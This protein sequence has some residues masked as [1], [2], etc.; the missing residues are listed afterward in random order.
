VRTGSEANLLLSG[1]PP[2]PSAY[3]EITTLD[4]ATLEQLMSALE[5]RAAN[6][7]ERAMRES[8]LSFMGLP[9]GARVLE[10]GCGTGAVSRDVAYRARIGE[11]VGLDPSPVFIARARELAAGVSNLIFEEG[12]AHNLPYEH[13]SFD[14]VIFHTCLSH[15]P[16]PEIALAEAHRV[17]RAGG[18]LAIFDGDFA[19]RTIAIGEHD[20]LQQCIEAAAASA[21]HDL[22]LM[23]RISPLVRSS[24]F[25]IDRFD[26]QGYVQTDAPDYVLT[27]VDRGADA[28]LKDGCV[29]REFADALKQAARRRADRGE[30]F[31]SIMYASLIARKNP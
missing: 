29:D 7:R 10:V 28:L 2:M 4:P 11:V 23:R 6:P 30:F 1:E 16:S 3:A 12:D 9:D 20:P 31:G 14:A 24:G 27:L 8:Y 5:S 26:N 22:W 25:Q 15:V 21:V 13:R 17:L 18:Y 19:S